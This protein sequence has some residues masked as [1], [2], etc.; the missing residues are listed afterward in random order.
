MLQASMT[1]QMA[2]LCQNSWEV[3]RTR[4]IICSCLQSSEDCL[5]WT[6]IA[7]NQSLLCSFQSYK[8]ICIKCHGFI[9]FKLSTCVRSIA[10]K[11]IQYCYRPACLQMA[12][13]SLSM[14]DQAA[15]FTSCLIAQVA[16]HSITDS[17]TRCVIQYLVQSMTSSPV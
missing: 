9:D 13:G 11:C 14:I 16:K 2:K 7:I 3:C 1:N 5:F 17:S 15:V 10:A 12:D 8:P 4:S 6:V